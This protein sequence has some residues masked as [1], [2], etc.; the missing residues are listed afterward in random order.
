MIDIDIARTR[1]STYEDE[2]EIY[3]IDG[4]LRVA[5]FWSRLEFCP[6]LFAV[7]GGMDAARLLRVFLMFIIVI[8]Q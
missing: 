4:A 5:M 3:V 1:T 8:L 6:V 7:E 2:P